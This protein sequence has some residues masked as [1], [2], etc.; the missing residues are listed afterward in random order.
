MKDRQKALRRSLWVSALAIVLCCAMLVGT[1]FAWFTDSVSSSGNKIEAGTLNITATAAGYDQNGGTAVTVPEGIIA[2]N[3]LTFGEAEDIEA[4]NAKPIISESNWEPGQR[5]AKL[6]TV[7]NSGSL[8]AKIKLEFN[9]SNGELTDALWFDFIQV[10][11]NTATGQFT[12]RDMS[13]LND[14]AGQVELPVPAGGSVSFILVYGMKE[15]AGNEYQGK[16]FEASVNILAKQ[17]T[18]E[19]DGFGNDQYDK[20]AGYPV[21][22]SDPNEFKDALNQGGE[23]TLA[24]D[25]EVTDGFQLNVKQDAKINFNGNTFK[26]T[27]SSGSTTNGSS[28]VDLVLSDP[29]NT[30]DYSIDGELVR[31]EGGGM[32]QTAAIAVWQPTVTV[33]SGKY[34][35]DNAVINCQLQTQD[36]GAVGVVINGGTFVGK[37]NA[38]VVANIFGTVVIN[39]GTFE[40]SKKETGAGECVYVSSGNRYV[41]SITTINGGTFSAEGRIFYIKK[42]TNYVQKVEVKGGNYTVAEGGTLVEV[43]DGSTAED[44]LTITGGTF[45]VDPSAYVDTEKY[46]VINSEN[47]WTV[48]E[49]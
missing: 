20:D 22:V 37:G 21:L 44:I 7:T 34:T 3:K 11:E 41:P 29:N 1:T 23:I 25:V 30:G 32:T 42:N 12:Q 13:T 18:V 40:A 49:R 48:T 36:S 38:S 43:S 46:K 33:E 47:L 35:H 31:H 4:E 28:G 5:N 24:G 19:E 27:L 8:A 14:L 2:G 6:L 39:G 16:G 26:G 45:N 10:N 9:V 15:S 17:N